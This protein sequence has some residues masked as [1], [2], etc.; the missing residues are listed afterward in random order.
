MGYAS[1]DGLTNIAR[2]P[3]CC[4][5]LN[6]GALIEEVPGSQVWRT[7]GA[8]ILMPFGVVWAK[9]HNLALL[10]W[11]HASESSAEKAIKL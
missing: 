3:L 8:F 5:L 4:R 11:F 1:N 2:T 7:L 9:E 6:H 10:L